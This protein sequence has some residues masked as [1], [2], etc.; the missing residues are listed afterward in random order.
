MTS[1]FASEYEKRSGKGC[2]EFDIVMRL[3]FACVEVDLRSQNLIEIG[4][5]NWIGAKMLWKVR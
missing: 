1:F 3:T 4:R 5:T 2:L